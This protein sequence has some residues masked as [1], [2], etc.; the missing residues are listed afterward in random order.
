[1]RNLEIEAVLAALKDKKGID[2][3]GYRRETIKKRISERII[4]YHLGGGGN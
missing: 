2:L 3:T 1:M 4:R